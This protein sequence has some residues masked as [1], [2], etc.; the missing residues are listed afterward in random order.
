MK[1]RTNFNNTVV[2]G[3]VAI[4]LW[5]LSGS[6]MCVAAQSPE[7]IR[8]GIITGHD[9]PHL[10]IYLDAVSQS[11]GVAK[12]AIS[13]DSGSEFKRAQSELGPAFGK[14]ATYRNP[15]RMID[16]FKPQLVIVTLPA[17]LSP[18]AIRLALEGGCNV[19]SEK[20]G[21]VR[22]EQFAE[23]VELARSK[24]LMLVLS[25]PSR[26]SPRALRA[27]EIVQQGLLGK[28]YAATVLTVK[29]Q[30]RLKRPDY[31]KM[32]FSFK[33]KA[34]GGHLI[35]LGIHDMD[36]LFFITGDR[37]EK[38]T[39]FCRNVGGQPVKIEDAEA[40]ALQFKSGMVG[41]FQGG[42]YLEG[43]SMQSGLT[44][45]GSQGWL[46]MSSHRGPEGST[47]SFQWY[48]THDNAPNKIQTENPTSKVGGYQSFVQAA[49][50]AARGIRP[51]PLTGEDSLQVLKVIFAAYRASET[52]AVQNVR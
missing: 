7:D 8:I 40:L 22:A 38:V 43:G 1:H 16:E 49:I 31:Q 36:K 44:I 26:V 34:G 20:P 46:R 33:D 51:A 6:H 28:L 48:S 4:L 50:D 13:D 3:A 14:V 39:A 45:W 52:D 23:L 2:I 5:T 47:S 35:W 10:D 15:A 9:G 42:Y 37:V 41:T 18:P 19:L 21:C 24:K 30:A 11:M 25:L 29:D 27:R 12:V 32:W 17:H